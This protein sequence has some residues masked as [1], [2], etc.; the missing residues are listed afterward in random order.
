MFKKMQVSKE[1]KK[2]KKKKPACHCQLIPRFLD[3]KY[4]NIDPSSQA[5]DLD[6]YIFFSES[7][8]V[9]E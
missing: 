3:A 1:Q 7:M 6:I 4:I 9:P 8:E 5:V 2:K